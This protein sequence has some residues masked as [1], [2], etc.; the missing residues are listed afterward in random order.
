MTN[1]ND[2]TSPQM[3]SYK[4]LFS[5]RGELNGSTFSMPRIVFLIIFIYVLFFF[6]WWTYTQYQQMK[7]VEVLRKELLSKEAAETGDTAK[8]GFI[9]TNEKYQDIERIA[10]RDRRKVLLGTVSFFLMLVLGLWFVDRGFRREIALANQQRNFLLS[11]THELKSPIASVRLIL[12]TFRKRE[13]NRQQTVRFANGSLKELDRLNQLVNNIL[14]AARVE[15]NNQWSAEKLEMNELIENILSQI[16]DKY[17]N[18]RF[19]ARFDGE[20]NFIVADPTAI[21]TIAFNLLENA[22][23]YSPPDKAEVQIIVRQK[24]GRVFFKVADKGI[25]IP[26]ED[27]GKIFEKFYRIGSED[28]R[29]TKGTG[30]GLYIVKQIVRAHNGSIVVRNNTPQGSVFEVTLPVA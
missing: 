30:L 29:K 5:S 11:I 9:T 18:V 13:L 24:R 8:V 19:S 27:K 21:T 25:G 28:T 22:V 23:K 3:T 10:S 16:R 12:E 7:E 4:N 2:K 1:T 20:S 14:L 17:P 26:D 6:G 15:N